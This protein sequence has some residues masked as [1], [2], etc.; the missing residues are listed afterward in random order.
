MARSTD[1]PKRAPIQRMSPIKNHDLV[2]EGFVSLTRWGIP[3]PPRSKGWIGGWC[4]RNGH[5]VRSRQDEPANLRETPVFAGQN[6]IS[7][8]HSGAWMPTPSAARTPI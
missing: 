6:R 2:G 4:D 1:D 5:G 8:I 7:M 3:E